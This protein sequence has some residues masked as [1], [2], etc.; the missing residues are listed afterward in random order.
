M[1]SPCTRGKTMREFEAELS[2]LKQENFE[3]K[4][5]I[6]VLEEQKTALEDV[7]DVSDLRIENQHLQ[8]IQ[9]VVLSSLKI[10]LE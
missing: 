1:T 4:M 8:V 7:R 3:L 10:V 9:M 2:E 5:K 6:Y